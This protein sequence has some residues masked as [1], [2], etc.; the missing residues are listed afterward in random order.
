[1]IEK[2]ITL[3]GMITSKIDHSIDFSKPREDGL[4]YDRRSFITAVTN[5]I[6]DSGGLY[7][8]LV[9]PNKKNELDDS[10][11]IGVV[12]NVES[13]FNE[14]PYLTIGAIDDKLGR[15]VGWDLFAMP[16]MDTYVEDDIIYITKIYYW[17]LSGNCN[18][19]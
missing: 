4:Y 17:Y 3:E 16:K 10:D 8:L 19:K 11:V 9:K 2:L 12:V 14:M 18:W 7:P 13:S 1:M 15:Y 5:C 6:L